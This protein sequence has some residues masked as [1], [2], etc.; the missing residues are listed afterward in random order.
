MWRT[1]NINSLPNDVLKFYLFPLLSPAALW[2]SSLVCRKW[3]TFVKDIP[4]RRVPLKQKHAIIS[5]YRDGISVEFLEWFERHLRFPIR[6]LPKHI[7]EDC[8]G[9]AAQGSNIAK[10]H[11]LCLNF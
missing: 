11:F 1:E 10:T 9:H 2:V 6:S 8:M 7:L 4:A 5:L 3:Y